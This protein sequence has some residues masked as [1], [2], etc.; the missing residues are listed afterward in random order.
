MDGKG[1]L[2]LPAAVKRS[3]LREYKQRDLFVTSLDGKFVMA[4]P[5]AQW[6]RVEEQLSQPPAGPEA[7][8]EADSNTRLLFHWNR[9]GAEESMDAQGRFLV[10]SPLRE[11]AGMK[12]TVMIQ[13][14]KTHMLI[15][16]KSKYEEQATEYALSEEE[17]LRARSM[18]L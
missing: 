17:M 14:E 2:K 12:G 15:M 7:D 8:R 18:G 16:N 11:E 9:W 3:I 1:R 10:P 6:E 5:F 13:W 4:Y